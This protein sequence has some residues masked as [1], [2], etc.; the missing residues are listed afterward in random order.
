MNERNEFCSYSHNLI[1]QCDYC[2]FTPAGSG[3]EDDI[4]QLTQRC[5]RQHETDVALNA[6]LGAC[7]LCLE[8]VVVGDR[9]AFDCAYQNSGDHP[10]PKI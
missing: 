4:T 10:P 5:I 1:S 7:I 6:I 9:S 2:Q 3:I 8:I